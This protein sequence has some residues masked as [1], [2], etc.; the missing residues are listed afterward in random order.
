VLTTY[1][2]VARESDLP[3]LDGLR[4]PIGG[5][6]TLTKDNTGPM[7]FLSYAIAVY[8]GYRFSFDRAAAAALFR[9]A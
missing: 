6:L 4:I 2:V 3:F 1:I 5:V 9:K 8:E 7:D